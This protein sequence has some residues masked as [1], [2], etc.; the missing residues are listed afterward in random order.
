MSYLVKINL[1]ENPS[2]K[3]DKKRLADL[4]SLEGIIFV[5]GDEGWAHPVAQ[6]CHCVVQV[7]T[8]DKALKFMS[9]LLNLE[10][11]GRLS[12][13]KAENQMKV[14]IDCCTDKT[15]YY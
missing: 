1:M 4:K 5:Y 3:D 10:Y 14:I 12:I 13:E 7:A 15:K 11:V 9:E 8:E 2:W 6:G